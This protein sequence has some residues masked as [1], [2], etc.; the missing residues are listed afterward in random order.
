MFLVDSHDPDLR[1]QS[2]YYSGRRAR[3][4]AQ[5]D[6]VSL[7][8]RF[9]DAVDGRNFN[10]AEREK[11]AP[12]RLRHYWS[13]LT[14][15]EIGEL[16]PIFGDGPIGQAAGLRADGRPAWRRPR[17]HQRISHRKSVLTTGCAFEASPFFLC[18]FN[19]LE[20]HGERSAVR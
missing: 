6:G 11:A 10:D 15:G 4:K 3:M 8:F 14:D 2:G 16:S 7:P 1:D 18:G 19:E 9:F 20:D 12:S 17:A 5:L 13:R